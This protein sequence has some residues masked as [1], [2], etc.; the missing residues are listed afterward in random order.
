MANEKYGAEAKLRIVRNGGETS[1]K[2]QFITRFES[3]IETIADIDNRSI[4]YVDPSS[5]SGFYSP[6]SFT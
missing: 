5:T 1:Y 3:G 2:G 4:A 6:Q